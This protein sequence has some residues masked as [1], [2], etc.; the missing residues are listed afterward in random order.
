MGLVGRGRC[1]SLH[2]AAL[3]AAPV[4]MTEGRDSRAAPV[5]MT[6]GRDSRAAPVGMT[7]PR[8][9]VIPSGGRGAAAVEGSAPPRRPTCGSLHSRLR[10][11][12]GMTIGL[13]CSVGITPLRGTAP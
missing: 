11:S 4:G 1:G 7:P 8:N 5:G 3:R 9:P 2:F 13:R 6:E 10:R 12:V